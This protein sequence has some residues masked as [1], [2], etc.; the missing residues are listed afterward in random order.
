MEEED[1]IGEPLEEVSKRD[2]DED[3]NARRDDDGRFLGYCDRTAGWGTDSEEGRCRTHGGNGGAPEGNQNAVTHGAYRR[4][5]IDSLTEG[6]QEA[7]EEV[8]TKLENPESA[9]EI[10]RN[11]AAYCLMMGH[12]SGSDRWFR[13]YEGICEKFGIAPEDELMVHHE[14]LEDAFMANL[15][16]YHEES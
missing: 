9:Q 6:E 15:K 5:A 2:P 1:L 10:A 16:E 11:A 4:R 3:C 7:F 12:R 13:R 14:G 8:A